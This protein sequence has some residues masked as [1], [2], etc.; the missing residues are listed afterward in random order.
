MAGRTYW[1]YI[2]PIEVSLKIIP[3]NRGTISHAE[4]G[5][6]AITGV[7]VKLILHQP[8]LLLNVHSDLDELSNDLTTVSQVQCW[9]EKNSIGS[10]QYRV[11]ITRNDEA[12]EIIQCKEIEGLPP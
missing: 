11:E 10:L 7:D 9:R 8:K 2:N 3:G 12:R 1:E 5:F 6:G 4:M